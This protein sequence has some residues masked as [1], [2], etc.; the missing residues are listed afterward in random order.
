MI[1]SKPKELIFERS[2]AKTAGMLVGAVLMTGL[3]Y[4]FITRGILNFAFDAW[5][6]GLILGSVAFV[7]NATSLFRGGPQVVFDEQGI[8]DLRTSWGLIAWNEILSLAIVPFY[9][10]RFL[11]IYLADESARIASL[12]LWGRLGLYA[13]HAK[14]FPAFNIR[15]QGLTRGLDEAWDYL[16]THHPE[17]VRVLPTAQPLGIARP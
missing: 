12:S 15:F 16:Q 3:S 11:C 8:N 9:G 2:I 6:L 5:L 4:Y 7:I 1:H 14:G 17:K 13:H 10:N